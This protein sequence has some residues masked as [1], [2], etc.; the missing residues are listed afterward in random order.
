MNSLLLALLALAL[1]VTLLAQ[2]T[3]PPERAQR[4][5]RMAN[6]ALGK[7]ADAAV[8]V[9]PDAD[10]AQGIGGSGA[11]ALV[12]PDRGFSADKVSS[13]GEQPVALGQLWLLGMAPTQN[14]AAPAHDS[15]RTVSIQTDDQTLRPQVYFLA[16]GKAADG[17]PE[18]LVYGKGKE[19]LLRAALKPA[20]VNFQNNPLELTGARDGQ[21]SGH[22]TLF[23]TG[24]QS[25]EI[26]VVKFGE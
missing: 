20:T 5:A 1:P 18:L 19:P 26:P 14:S 2:D 3:I 25:A 10:H 21:D 22:L 8:A 23:I 16:L 15:V 6:E 11:G 7:V 17:K 4:G 12:V 9:D 24:Q 13:V